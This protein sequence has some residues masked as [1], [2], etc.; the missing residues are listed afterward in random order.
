MD[1]MIIIIMMMHAVEKINNKMEFNKSH[2]NEFNHHS[3][4]REMRENG[5]RIKK[6]K[7]QIGFCDSLLKCPFIMT[8]FH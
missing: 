5:R 3:R 7:M 6:S 4:E 8:L 2:L 1:E